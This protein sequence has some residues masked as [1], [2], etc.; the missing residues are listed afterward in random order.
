[1]PGDD[2]FPDVLSVELRPQGDRVYD[3]VVTI[4]SPYDSPRRYADGWRVMDPEGM[5]LG[6]HAL[7][8][9]HAEEQPF[10]RTQRGLMIPSG[11]EEV[12]VQGRDLA[13]GY[14]GRTVTVALPGPRR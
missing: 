6:N 10:T 7:L 9:G 3:V 12:I 1:M 11:V 4:S 14:G 5:V 2:R 8:H 13:S